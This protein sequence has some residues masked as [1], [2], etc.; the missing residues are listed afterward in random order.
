MAENGEDNITKHLPMPSKI[1]KKVEMTTV[2]SVSVNQDYEQ[3]SD[4]Y[5]QNKVTSTTTSTTTTKQ[6]KISTETN[7]EKNGQNKI[8]KK[9]RRWSYH[10]SNVIDRTRQGVVIQVIDQVVYKGLIKGKG[11]FQ[12]KM[13]IDDQ[14]KGHGTGKGFSVSKKAVN[15]DMV[16]WGV[17]VKEYLPIL[18]F[19]NRK[20]KGVSVF[21]IPVDYRL[22][23]RLL[24][25]TLINVIIF[26]VKARVDVL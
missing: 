13:T 16:E 21:G 23:F 1:G 24:S 3:E 11:K 10:D 22:F 12:D 9:K 7:V 4:D 2:L 17:L 25:I 20:F 15:V 5:S 26:G 14:E 6:S 18:N 19:W 8:V